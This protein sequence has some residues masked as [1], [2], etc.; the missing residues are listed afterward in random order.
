MR[1]RCAG[2]LLVLVLAACGPSEPDPPAQ[3]GGANVGPAAAGSDVPT[4]ERTF[5]FAGFVGDSVI[6]VPWLM[7]TFAGTD[8]AVH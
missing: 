2:V 7:R 1:L 5:A 4:Y 3:T 8:S 6:L